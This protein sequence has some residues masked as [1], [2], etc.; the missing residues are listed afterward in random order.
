MDGPFFIPGRDLAAVLGTGAILAV[1]CFAAG[2]LVGLLF[3]YAPGQLIAGALLKFTRAFRRGDTISAGGAT[4]TVA[5]IRW[6]STQLVLP[7]NTTLLVP[8]IDLMSSTVI[9]HTAN[10]IRRIDIFFGIAHGS[11]LEAAADIIKEVMAKDPRILQQPSAGIA[12]TESDA[13]GVVLIAQPWVSVREYSQ[14]CSDTTLSIHRLFA[15]EG[16]RRH[17]NRSRYHLCNHGPC[18]TLPAS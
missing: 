12:I 6:F 15:S 16:I 10:G 5:S 3:R 9:N 1:G 17:G 11:D 14:V 8:N 4:G 18:S 7:D 13:G 2:L